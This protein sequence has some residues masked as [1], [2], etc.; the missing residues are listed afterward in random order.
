MNENT[1]MIEIQTPPTLPEVVNQLQA[2]LQGTA[3]REAVSNWAATWV[4]AED[5][6]VEDSEV[7]ELLGLAA[8]VDLQVEPLEY[9]H[10]EADI[11]SWIEQFTSNKVGYSLE[12][13]L[14]NYTLSTH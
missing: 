6:N 7:W 2:I 8:G 1:T 11:R 3:D 5:P 12:S 9:L 13:Q 14:Q 4:M 10:P